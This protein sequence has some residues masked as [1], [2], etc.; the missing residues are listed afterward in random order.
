VTERRRGLIARAVAYVSG[1]RDL[2][3]LQEQV[4]HPPEAIR[5]AATLLSSD[6]HRLTHRVEAVTRL[7]GRRSVCLAREMPRPLGVVAAAPQITRAEGA[8]LGAALLRAMAIDA[9]VL[10]ATIDDEASALC[11]WRQQS[12]PWHPVPIW[13]AA[14]VRVHG[15]RVVDAPEAD[16]LPP[17]VGWGVI[18]SHTRITPRVMPRMRELLAAGLASDPIDREA[19]S[20]PS[21]QA[22][23]RRRRGQNGPFWGCSRFPSCRT[24]MPLTDGRSLTTAT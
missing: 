11:V 4:E 19:P 9:R 6:Q 2:D 18:D 5:R 7:V 14:R 21:C 10:W 3:E 8:V 20:C 22:E 15:E 17:L 1:S 12:G 23:M 24:T 13:P 16:Q